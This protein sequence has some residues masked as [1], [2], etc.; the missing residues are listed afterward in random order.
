MKAMPF[1]M[2]DRFVVDEKNKK[3]DLYGWIKREKDAYKDFVLIEYK[4]QKE[5]LWDSSYSTSS[6]KYDKEIFK[7]LGCVGDKP[8]KCNR[9]ESIFEIKNMIKIN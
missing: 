2:W 3:I 1:V 9:V 6:A 7:E 5:K 8:N 4:I